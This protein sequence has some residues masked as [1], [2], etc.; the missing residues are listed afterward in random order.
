MIILKRGKLSLSG[1]TT[2]GVTGIGNLYMPTTVAN[3]SAVERKSHNSLPLIISTMMG[4]SKERRV[5]ILMVHSFTAISYSVISRTITDC[6]ASTAI[7]G[8]PETAVSALIGKV[9]RLSRKRVQ[10]SGWKRPLPYGVMI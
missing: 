7:S 9:Q 2:K 4:V 8:E 10:P 1:I 6:F 5:F 3:A